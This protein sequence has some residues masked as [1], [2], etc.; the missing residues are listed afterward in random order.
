MMIVRGLEAAGIATVAITDEFAGVD[1]R[2]QSLADTAA[3][4]DAV[5]S[6]GNANALV[7]LPAMSRVLGPLDRVTSLAG[8][9][10]ESVRADGR[11]VVELQA[12]VGATNALGQGRLRAAEVRR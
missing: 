5:I 6:T 10:P 4:A 1:G 3:E 12:I 7:E 11:L 8:A 9:S 2:S